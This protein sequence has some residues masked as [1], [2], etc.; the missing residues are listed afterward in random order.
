MATPGADHAERS[1][2]PPPP[3]LPGRVTLMGFALDAVTQAQAL[4]H[5]A[6]SIRAGVGGW[7]VT[8]NLDI[9]RRI[10]REPATR[11]LCEM[12]T[13]RLADGMPLIWASRLRGTPLPERVP[14][15][16]LIL[17]LSERAA[18]EGLSVYL[19]GGDPG[20]GDAAAAKLRERFPAIRIVGVESPPFGFERDDAYMAAMA[21]RVV[22]SRA[23]I[24]F[25]AV[26][27]PKQERV[28]E[29]LRPLMPRAWFLGVGISFSFVTGHVQ[30][31]PRWVQRIGLEW[32]T[33]V[34]QEP[35][36][37]FKRY[38]VHGVPFAVYLL[39]ASTLR[40]S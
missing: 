31:A 4:D 29:R 39:V 17:T 40:R 8:P 14:G 11:A 9:L 38:F 18:R 7:V 23:D 10:V 15:S 21:Q 28:I 36:R 26:G 35:R 30:R 33:R 13:L 27:F 3:T 1:S 12:A 25:V 37:L 5:I 20:V 24:V 22:A 2:P 16:D 6:A 19:L 32:L 34:I